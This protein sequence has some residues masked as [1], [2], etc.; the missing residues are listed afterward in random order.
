MK[1]A[2]EGVADERD[3][4]QSWEGFSEAAQT[5]GL[6][7]HFFCFCFVSCKLSSARVSIAELGRSGLHFSSRVGPPT[8][9]GAPWVPYFENPGGARGRCRDVTTL[10]PSFV[11]SRA[12][13]WPLVS[14]LPMPLVAANDR[15]EGKGKKRN[16]TVQ[17]NFFI[18][19]LSTSFFFFFTGGGG[20]MGVYLPSG[21]L[22]GGKGGFVLVCYFVGYHRYLSSCLVLSEPLKGAASESLLVYLARS[23]L[24]KRDEKFA[25]F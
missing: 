5:V 13:A 1:S 21:L 12:S 15:R 23:F 10:F 8:R 11:C 18:F 24:R 19:F 25:Y 9:C 14:S 17:R 6:T 2:D 7:F 20:C 4:A 16:N 22:L 3:A